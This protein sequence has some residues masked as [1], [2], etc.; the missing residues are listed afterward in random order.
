MYCYASLQC[1]T[2]R[3]NVNKLVYYELFHDLEEAIHR[4]KQIKGWRR[5]RKID[6][7]E[8]VNPEWKELF[9]DMVFE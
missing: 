9:D 7:I 4:E 8:S 5:S 1:F 2:Y 3:Y 6:L